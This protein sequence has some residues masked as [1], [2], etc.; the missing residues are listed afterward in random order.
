M[1]LIGTLVAA[2]VELLTPD[3]TMARHRFRAWLDMLVANFVTLL[4]IAL[5][6]GYQVFRLWARRTQRGD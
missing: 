3:G 5:A 1:Y 6:V 2:V 4:A